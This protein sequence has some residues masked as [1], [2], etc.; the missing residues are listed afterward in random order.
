[1]AILSYTG[2]INTD[3]ILLGRIFIN[4]TVGQHLWIPASLVCQL[5]TSMCLHV[6]WSKRWGWHAQR[7]PETQWSYT[8]TCQQNCWKL[9]VW[10]SCFFLDSFW[11]IGLD[12]HTTWWMYTYPWFIC[13]FWHF[14]WYT[15]TYI[16]HVRFYKWPQEGVWSIRWEGERC[17]A[18]LAAFLGRWG[19]LSGS[20]AN[21]LLTNSTKNHDMRN[22]TWSISMKNRLC[23]G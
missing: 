23:T 18:E 1:M 19:L 3:H 2:L 21:G 4:G 11:S 8:D 16:D 15:S 20:R 22:S 17:F 5:G 12:A 7:P 13:V 6:V 9:D 10:I 14:S